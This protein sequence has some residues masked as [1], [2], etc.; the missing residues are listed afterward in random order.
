M[1]LYMNQHGLSSFLV[2]LNYSL[3]HTSNLRHPEIVQFRVSCLEFWTKHGLAAAID[4]S[5]KSKSTL[6]AWRKALD[7]SRKKDRMGRASL[8][9]LDPKTTRPLR[10]KSNHWPPIVVSF[11]TKTATKHASMGKQMLYHLLRRYLERLG[12]LRLLVSESTVG[13]IL[14]WLRNMGKVPSKDRIRI[15]GRSGKLHIVPKKRRI[16]KQRRADLPFKV[17][18]PGDLVQIDG[19]EGFHDGHHYYIINAIDYVSGL[20]ASRVFKTKSTTKTA[21]FLKDLPELLGFK[22]KAIQTDN[23]SEYVAKFH[24]QAEAMGIAHCFNYVKKPIYNGKV[25]RFNRTMQEEL[26]YDLDFLDALAYDLES[27]QTTINSFI[28]FYNNVRPHSTINF[29]TPMERMLQC[30]KR[31]SFQN[32]LN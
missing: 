11:I 32:V 20:A 25:E 10:C 9:A 1:A 19:I 5:G 4:Y 30:F 31:N 22:V 26:K 3:K 12:Q 6:Y 16:R 18:N 8:S 23:G 2:N 24:E 29:Q 28:Y 17:R 21:S 27:A 15:N 13:R 7:D 14:K